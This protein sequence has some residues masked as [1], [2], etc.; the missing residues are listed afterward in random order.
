MSKPPRWLVSCSRNSPRCF[1]CDHYGCERDI[2]PFGIAIL[3]I[4]SH[5]WA[6]APRSASG[7]HA[8]DGHEHGLECLAVVRVRRGHAHDWRETGPVGHHVDHRA[9][10]AAST[11]FGPVRPS[12]FT[13]TYVR[14]SS[15]EVAEVLAALTG[16]PHPL[17]PV[18]GGGSRSS[19]RSLSAGWASMGGQGPSGTAGRSARGSPSTSPRPG[20][21]WLPH[22]RPKSRTVRQAGERDGDSR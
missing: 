11:G 22:R 4:G 18:D 13:T 20:L 5:R 12:P 3:R 7:P 17:G 10:P 9:G 19:L 21:P 14:A 6:K 15:T 2:V 16:E 1:V 8:R